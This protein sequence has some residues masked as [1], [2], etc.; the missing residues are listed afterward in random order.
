MEIMVLKEKNDVE[1]RKNL[2]KRGK[3]EKM[4]HHGKRKRWM[5]VVEI[6]RNSGK[7]WKG[8]NDARECRIKEEKNVKIQKKEKSTEEKE[9]NAK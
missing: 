4:R 5:Y 1:Q 9:N 3:R 8:K 2:K 6:Y 7:K